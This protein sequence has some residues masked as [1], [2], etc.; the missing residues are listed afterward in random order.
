MNTKTH[1][2][3]LESRNKLS[4]TAIDEVISFDEDTVSLAV[5]ET[6]LTIT[7]D[8]LA[9]KNLSIDCGE[10]T[11]EGNITAMVYFDNAPRK[12]RLFGKK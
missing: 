1:S 2:L 12:K 7:G 10:V 8:S 9:V 4:L 5:G 11:V 3:V 6:V